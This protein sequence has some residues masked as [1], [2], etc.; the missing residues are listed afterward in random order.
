MKTLSL[1]I[2]FFKNFCIGGTIIGMYSLVIKYLSPVLAGHMSGSLPLVFTYVIAN[3]YYI[4]G[5]EKA[6]QTSMVGFRG[7]FFWL[8]YAFIIFMMLK[9]E[10]N[11]IL[12]FL[13]A[14]S[15]FILMSYILYMYYKH[16]NLLPAAP[17]KL[18]KYIKLSRFSK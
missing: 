11:I 5:Y 7:G 3:T 16:S 17:V 9:Y 8:T 10:Q 2:D 18:N 15:V 12:T 13:L 1:V 14:I 4:H 6:Q